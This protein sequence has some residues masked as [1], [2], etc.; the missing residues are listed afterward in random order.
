MV[1]KG[2]RRAQLKDLYGDRASNQYAEVFMQKMQFRDDT[3]PELGSLRIDSIFPAGHLASVLQ[4]GVPVYA[5]AGWYDLSASTGALRMFLNS[6]HPESKMLLGAWHHAGRNRVSPFSEVVPIPFDRHSEVLK[7]F[8]RHLKGLDNGIAEEPR[9]HY[10]HMGEEAWRGSAQ[11]PLPHL[12]SETLYLGAGQQLTA[13]APTGA[14]VTEPAQLEADTYLGWDSRWELGGESRSR[15]DTFLI[16]EPKLIAYTSEPFAET[17]DVSGI[18]HVKLFLKVPTA[19][20]NVFVYLIDL[21]PDG[22]RRV[23]ATGQ[24][25]V[26]FRTPFDG[27]AP[28][29]DVVPYQRFF[30]ADWQAVDPDGVT[31]LDIDFFPTSWRIEAGHAVRV[32]VSG[33]DLP[34]FETLDPQVYDIS[35]VYGPD[36]PARVELPVVAAPLTGRE[37]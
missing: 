5:F 6:T 15:Y 2:P 7:F 10:Y 8:D 11:W 31:E 4:S 26:G 23:V 9:V 14:T 28:Y 17:T 32:V 24:Q 30:R 35:M 25:K 12:R 13:E 18:P 19:D 37:E 22:T 21:A 33:S 29:R 34:H 1:E 3:V 20:A 16:A 27:P 36:Y